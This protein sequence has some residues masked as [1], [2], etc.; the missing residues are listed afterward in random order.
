MGCF[1]RPCLIVASL[2][3]AMP[4][5]AQQSDAIGGGLTVPPAGTTPPSDPSRQGPELD[6]YRD[7]V[8]PRSTP[9]VTS[10]PVQT[11]R[12]VPPPV[13]VQPVPAPAQPRTRPT[14]QQASPPAREPARQV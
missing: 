4:V 13:T 14:P 9:P 3:L 8:T 6:V 10:P 5:H 2:L 12:I 11:Q 7:P 1:S